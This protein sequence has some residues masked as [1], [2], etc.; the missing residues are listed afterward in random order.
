[1]K[2]KVGEIAPDFSLPDQNNKKHRLSD[3]RGAFVL[4]YFYPK[5]DTPGCATEAMTIRD[6]FQDFKAKKVVVL[7]VSGDSVESHKKFAQK[8]ALPF[9]LLADSENSVLERYGVFEKKNLFGKKSL[10]IKRSSVLIDQAGIISKIYET[11]K[12]ELHAGQVLEDLPL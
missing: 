11:V 7:G 4:L 2:V 12:P 6:V 9:V 8:Y 3:Y 10:G 5:D 1:M